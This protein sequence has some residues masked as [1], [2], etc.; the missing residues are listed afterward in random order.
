MNNITTYIDGNAR[1]AD[2]QFTPGLGIAP[3]RKT[4]L[5]GCLD[6]RV[7]PAQ[8]FRFELGDV[9]IIR[10]IG[11]RITPAVIEEIALLTTLSQVLGGKLGPGWDLI[12]LQHTDCGITRLQHSPDELAHY[13][14][15]DTAALADKHVDDPVAAIVTDIATLRNAPQIPGTFTITGLMY[16]V[17]T[18]RVD[19]VANSAPLG[20][21]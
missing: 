20:S 8:I 5:V 2:T 4:L 3:A 6:P 9:G 15:V 1:F 16:D 12:V 17:A 18:G 10:N 11:G 13:F 14:G 21:S 7:D 19:N